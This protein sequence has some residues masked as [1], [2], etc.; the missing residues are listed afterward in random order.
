MIIRNFGAESTK[1]T[2]PKLP[3]LFLYLLGSILILN[4]IQAQFT[5][6]IF[7]EAYYWY[8]SKTY[9]LGISTIHPWSPG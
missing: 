5:E 2:P 4:L 9:P 1:L 3:R 6:L 8:Y 7:D